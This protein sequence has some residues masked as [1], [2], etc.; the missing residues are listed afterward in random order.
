MSL[1][2]LKPGF[3][4]TV[5]DGGRRGFRHL[6]VA[7]AGALDAVSFAIANSLAGNASGAAV[8]EIT[9]TGPRLRFLRAVRIAVTGADISVQADGVAVPSWRPV[10][11]AEG[12]EVSFGVCERGARAYLAVDGGIAVKAVMG[13]ASTDLRGGFGGM[14][15][16][17]LA[18]GDTLRFGPGLAAGAL[19]PGRVVHWF[20]DPRPDLDLIAPALAHVLPGSDTLVSPAALF[21]TAWGVSSESNRQALRLAGPPLAPTLPGERISEPVAPGTIQLPPDGQPIVL[22]AD[23]Q[24]VGGY[25]RIGYVAS[26]DLPRLGQLRPGETLRFTAA[27]AREATEAACEQRHRLA[28]I[29]E[30]VAKRLDEE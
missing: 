4:T 15:G 10:E 26:T 8:L 27:T 3:Q 22:L 30:A 6:G 16:R 1:E 9:I 14:E 23:A 13:S 7:R 29:A 20:V 12:S 17:A 2:V 28:R 18:A 21:E 25:P 19:H 24:T 5:Q 11:V